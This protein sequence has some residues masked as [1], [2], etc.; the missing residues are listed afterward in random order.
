MSRGRANLALVLALAACGG[1]Q[2][3]AAPA[4]PSCDDAAKQLLALANWDSQGRASPELA[5]G[6]RA[7]FARD[8]RDQHW[9]AER[10]TCIYN[11]LS[12]E[13]TLDC[14]KQ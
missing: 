12:Q 11:A 14:P 5:G 3:P 2:K 7:Q 13:Q 1:S 4:A 10:R 6:I 8:C 9:S